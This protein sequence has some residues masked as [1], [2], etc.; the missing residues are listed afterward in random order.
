ME[1]NSRTPLYNWEELND[2]RRNMEIIREARRNK[3]VIPD[4]LM[5]I[6]CGLQVEP[7][8][9]G[10]I[11]ERFIGIEAVEDPSEKR[12][13]ETM[14]K[15]HGEEWEP[16]PEPSENAPDEPSTRPV[17]SSTS[18]KKVDREKVMAL[19]KAGWSLIKIADETG[20]SAQRVRQ[21]V[22]EENSK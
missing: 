1:L 19:H 11:K 13:H 17:D 20:C 9:N 15:L 4:K 3:I 12:I 2:D 8:P 18:R 14:M 5:D 7:E 6:I 22:K 10:D 21:I 16:E